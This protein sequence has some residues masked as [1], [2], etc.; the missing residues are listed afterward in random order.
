MIFKKLFN[1]KKIV[2]YILSLQYRQKITIIILI[3]TLLPLFILGPILLAWQWDIRVDEILGNYKNSISSSI[4]MTSRMVVS[5]R[6]KFPYISSNDNLYTILTTDFFQNNPIAYKLIYTA[7]QNLREEFGVFRMDGYDSVISVY[8]IND[9]AIPGEYSLDYKSLDDKTR[10]AMALRKNGEILYQYRILPNN[11]G[12]N[13]EYYCLYGHVSNI[14]DLL[15]IAEIKIPFSNI[16][17]A[18][19]FKI[20]D[21]SFVVYIANK[22]STQITLNG[23]EADKNKIEQATKNYLENKNYGNYLAITKDISYNKDMLSYKDKVVMF[24]PKAYIINQMLGFIIISIVSML[25]IIASIFFSVKLTSSLITR[26]LENLLK[27]TNTNVDV[28]L[29]ENKF[30]SLKGNDEFSKID[31]KFYELVIKIKDYYRKVSQYDVEK[32]SLEL[33]LLQERINPHF[34]YNTLSSIKWAFPNDNLKKLIDLMVKYY[35]TALNKGEEVLTVEQEVE[36]IE[37]Y[38]QLQKFAYRSSMEYK[39]NIDERIKKYRI[40]KH[41]LQPIVENAILHG[42]N[43]LEAG[44]LIV[45][46]G[47]LLEKHIG[48][49]VSDNGVGMSRERIDGILCGEYQGASSGYGI[50]NLIERLELYFNE[51][52]S[53]EIISEIDK[54]TTVKVKLPIN[55]E[56]LSL[57]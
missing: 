16:R 30:K 56:E 47:T 25:F 9:A 19:E 45:I 57:S 33:K 13:S 38:I 32:K 39:M 49:E 48:F 18:F 7:Y 11:F 46:E 54:G 23:R 8:A 55:K 53:I 28:L 41:L 5:S 27:Q 51:N 1:V 34:L 42:I 4:D 44:G 31:A 21:K 10:N 12:R 20:P 14:K 15:G 2:A 3:F 6:Q 43:G 24:I 26:R 52:Y 22:G 40:F 50:K 35:R 37:T 36:M 29:E 17:K